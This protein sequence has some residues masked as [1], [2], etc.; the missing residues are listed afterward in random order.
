LWREDSVNTD[1]LSSAI[2]IHYNNKNRYQLALPVDTDT[3]NSECYVY[4]HTREGKGQPLGAWT[5]FDNHDVTAW[6]NLEPD[7]YLGTTGGGVFSYRR[8]GDTTDYRDDT[9]AID[10]QI[11]YKACSF[12]DEAQ[13]KV[14]AGIMSHWRSVAETSGTTLEVAID[15]ENSFD[16]GG[17]TEV[18][19]TTATTGVAD[20]F[21]SKVET[22]RSAVPKRRFNYIQPKFS[23]S[24]LD[25]P[26]ELAG[27]DFVVAGIGY[28]GVK[29]SA[30]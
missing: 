15:L 4:D 9:S 17:S 12:G 18:E 19:L 28:K 30:S 3:D 11:T 24:T 5:R 27:I 8:Q 10:A 1:S 16:S 22:L 13:R 29:E 25:E 7:L 20:E 6:V 2:G 14:C 26:I 23:N 21:N